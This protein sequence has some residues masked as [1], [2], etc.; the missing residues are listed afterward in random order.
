M[1]NEAPQYWPKTEAIFRLLTLISLLHLSGFLNLNQKNEMNTGK[2]I[3][4]LSLE[5]SVWSGIGV[6]KID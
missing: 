3:K 1:Y 4:I 5:K 6:W 2:W